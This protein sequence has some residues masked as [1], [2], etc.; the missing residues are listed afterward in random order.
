MMMMIRLMRIIPRDNERH[1]CVLVG[2]GES[3]CVCIDDI[4]RN[5]KYPSVLY[6]E[7]T[8]NILPVNAWPL[9]HSS[10]WCNCALTYTH[11]HT[12]THIYKSLPIFCFNPYFFFILFKFFFSSFLLVFFFFVLVFCRCRE[13]FYVYSHELTEKN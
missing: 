8:H 7:G 6:S 9:G 10:L 13:L 12:H 11:P 3:I 1:S 5:C 4:Q 2:D